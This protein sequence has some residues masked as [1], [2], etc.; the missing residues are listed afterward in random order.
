[1]TVGRRTIHLEEPLF[2]EDTSLAGFWGGHEQHC[3]PTSFSFTANALFAVLTRA[4][5]FGSTSTSTFDIDI[6]DISNSPFSDSFQTFSS[7]L[8]HHSSDASCLPEKPL[9]ARPK[10]FSV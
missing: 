5:M 8:R 3:K 4:A 9:G 6:F 2:V 10:T 1:L 7:R